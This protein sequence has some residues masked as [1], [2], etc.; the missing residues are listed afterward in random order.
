MLFME[1]LPCDHNVVSSHRISCQKDRSSWGENMF[2]LLAFVLFILFYTVIQ[3]G[4][5]LE[6]GENAKISA[7]TFPRHLSE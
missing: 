4:E 1:Q 2:T 5:K 3:T 7:L 6:K